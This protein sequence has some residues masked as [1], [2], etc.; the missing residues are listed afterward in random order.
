MIGAG[1]LGFPGAL[2]AS[3][4]LNAGWLAAATRRRP[5]DA[6]LAASTGIAVGVPLLHFTLWPWERWRG[7]PV[8][9]E[10]EGLPVRLLPVYNALLY[11]WAA[12]GVAALVVDTPRRH[13]RVGAMALAGVLASRPLVR[14][15]FVWIEREARRN[16]RWWN[17]AWRSAT[18]GR[19]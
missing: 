11:A 4:A 17:R 9:T 19:L 12:S 5:P 6:L 16:P 7:V 8:L 18:A 14:R 15:H 10:A 3:A 2:A 1:A 13:R